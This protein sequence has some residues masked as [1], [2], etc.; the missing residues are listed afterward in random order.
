MRRT[1]LSLA[2]AF[3]LLASSCGQGT[4]SV[5][6][7]PES[8]TGPVVGEVK[9]T[10][11]A[12]AVVAAEARWR[13][14]ADP[15]AVDAAASAAAEACLADNGFPSSEGVFP[16][17][18]FTAGANLPV[19]DWT[20]D[21]AERYGYGFTPTIEQLAP[22]LLGFVA[23]DSAATIDTTGDITEPAGLT[24]EDLDRFRSTVEQ[25]AA[26]VTDPLPDVPLPGGEREAELRARVL[27]VEDGYLRTATADRLDGW[28]SCMGEDLKYGDDP[29]S[30]SR[31][32]ADQ[33]GALAVQVE[34]T[35]NALAQQEGG[36]PG[37]EPDAA[38]VAAV[39]DAGQWRRK[40]PGLNGAI[41]EEIRVA[42]HDRTCWEQEVAPGYA[43][44][45]V[46]ELNAL[47]EE[48]SDVIGVMEQAQG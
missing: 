4:E 38:S 19:N 33:L 42:T 14:P 3:V 23:A 24:S 11:G 9:L 2:V 7:G 22:V 34:N 8:L 1:V 36:S 31:Y 28:R 21:F 47:A 5:S 32:F 40:V 37:G 16:P 13:T 18:Y 29:D 43:A 30:M 6:A 35:V 46:A 25:C 39:L 12:E 41:T 26:E 20:L 17:G 15:A 45:R 44:A 27:E 10:P 48:Y